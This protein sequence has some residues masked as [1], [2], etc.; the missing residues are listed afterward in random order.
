MAKR[1]DEIRKRLS[2]ATPGP[3]TAAW[4]SGGRMALNG[5]DGSKITGWLDPKN[6][7][8]IAN[9]HADLSYLLARNEKMEGV[10]KALRKAPIG[11]GCHE[12]I[13]DALGDE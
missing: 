3:W 2:D 8:L 6:G 9:A 4:V 1:T 7:P 11:D 10:L 13:D 12:L 5:A